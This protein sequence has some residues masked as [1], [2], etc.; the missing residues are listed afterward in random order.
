MSLRAR[1]RVKPFVTPLIE[2]H[3]AFCTGT[4]LSLHLADKKQRGYKPAQGHTAVEPGLEA[5]QRDSC[6][7]T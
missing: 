6:I 3:Q 2:S 1:P 5:P 7:S 4:A